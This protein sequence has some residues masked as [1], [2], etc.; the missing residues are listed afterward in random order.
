MIEA[1]K[2]WWDKAS[3]AYSMTA[4]ERYLANSVDMVDLERRQK[5][6]MYGNSNKFNY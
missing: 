5:Q 6:L 2:A 1:I 3:T 4:D